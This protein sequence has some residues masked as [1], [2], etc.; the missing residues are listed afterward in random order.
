MSYGATLE[1]KNIAFNE[2]DPKLERTSSLF[3][4]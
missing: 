1:R 2:R 4:H 3:A